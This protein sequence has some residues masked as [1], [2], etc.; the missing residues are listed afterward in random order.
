MIIDCIKCNNLVSADRDSNYICPF[1][2]YNSRIDNMNV[3]NGISKIQQKVLEC[4]H[5]KKQIKV[6]VNSL[7]K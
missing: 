5:C 4:P 3:T 2:N 7:T 6:T 1:C